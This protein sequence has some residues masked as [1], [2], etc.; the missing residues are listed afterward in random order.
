MNGTLNGGLNGANGH[1]ANGA[2]AASPGFASPPRRKRRRFGGAAAARDAVG[3]V[4]LGNTCYMNSVLQALV[5]VP[6]LRDFFVAAADDGGARRRGESFD[7]QASR[8]SYEG[9]AARVS[10]GPAPPPAEPRADVESPFSSSAGYSQ[11]DA[12]EFLAALLDGLHEDLNLPRERTRARAKA[13]QRREERRARRDARDAAAAA[14]AA[15]RD[16]ALRD[17]A[18]RRAADGDADADDLLGG[19]FVS[20]LR[21]PRCDHSSTTHESFVC[22]SLPLRRSAGAPPPRRMATLTLDRLLKL[23]SG[24]ERLDADDAWACPTCEA[25]VRAVKQLRLAA[26]PPVLVVHLKRFEMLGYHSAKLETCVAVHAT[27]PVDVGR[28]IDGDGD[29]ATYYLC[30]VVNHYGTIEFGHYTAY[31]RSRDDARWR[32]FNDSSVSVVEDDEVSAPSRAAYIL[33]FLR[34]DIAPPDWVRRA[35]DGAAREAP[36]PA[37]IHE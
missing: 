26:S 32:L 1:E 12:H 35:K 33:F 4:N 25:R 13:R 6:P 2:A 16:E 9:G 5:H 31:A 24:R 18:A 34:E 17:A 21:C 23:F 20:E 19:R 8:A 29:G 7:S 36:P 37:T 27:A 11:H 10:T 28:F 30:A 3:L 22:V 14:A 15:M